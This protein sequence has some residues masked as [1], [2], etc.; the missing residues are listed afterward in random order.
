MF[1]HLDDPWSFDE[2]L[3]DVRSVR[4]QG[5]RLQ[6]R[7]QVATLGTTAVALVSVL[8]A[9]SFASGGG[10]TPDGI[11][12]QPPAEQR[13]TTSTSLVDSDTETPGD[14]VPADV[15][16]TTTPASEPSDSG[17]G[18]GTGN[19]GR[20]NS[21][22]NP[23]TP[24]QPAP[25]SGTPGDTPSDPGTGTPD[26]T[27]SEIVRT[28]VKDAHLPGDDNTNAGA[29]TSI[30][31]RNAIPGLFG[32]N[33]QGVDKA[34]VTKATLRV[35]VCTNAAACAEGPNGWPGAT[36]GAISAYKLRDGYERWEQGNGASGSGVTANCVLDLN[37]ANTAN[38]CDDGISWSR[39][40]NH[41]GADLNGPARS[42]PT[43]TNSLTDGTV[44][45]FDVTADVQG[46]LDGT[47][48][49]FF[50][51]KTSSGGGNIE[52][53]SNEGAIAVGNGAFAPTLIITSN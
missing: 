45:E 17:S 12:T 24:S 29:A 6:V 33:V 16:V 27:P 5:R 8:G 51:R 46:A 10:G 20:P 40:N 3:A 11:A 41:G 49:S 14:T 19:P 44:I 13:N 50:L 30:L 42:G 25:D 9:A 15:T 18:G 21:P 1:E 35:T 34:K 26:T 28:A 36:G 22:T 48:V 38:D 2:P 52:F 37:I 43:I 4:K 53:Y 23:G 32:F 31:V 39:G 47:Y 7:R